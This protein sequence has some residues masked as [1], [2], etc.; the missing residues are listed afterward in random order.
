MISICELLKKYFCFT[1]VIFIS[2][3]INC[4]ECC[5]CVFNKYSVFCLKIFTECALYDSC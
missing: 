4:I 5:F 1:N 2:Y 3:G